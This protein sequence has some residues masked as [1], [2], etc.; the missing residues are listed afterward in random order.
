M[1]LEQ[2]KY[3][4]GKYRPPGTFS[5]HDRE[6]WTATIERL[7]EKLTGLVRG[8]S[9]DRLNWAYRP[10]GWSIR[11]VV[12]HLADSHMNSFVRFK[13]AM[14][15]ESPTIRP[16]K[17]DRWAC[18]PDCDRAEVGSSLTILEGLHKRMTMLFK[19]MTDTDWK[20]TVY[21]P[22]YKKQLTL[23]WMLGLYAWHSGHHL[24][25]IQQAVAHEGS[26]E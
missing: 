11:Q 4:V 18:T 26:F 14:T 20:R 5:A 8:L 19:N 17:E 6:E 25:H 15:E 22:D 10:G 21:H 13:W 12:H 7:P 2:L 9:Y 16:Y 23:E 1:D 24:A 3:P